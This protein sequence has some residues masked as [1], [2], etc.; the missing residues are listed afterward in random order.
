LSI[1][2]DFDRAAVGH[3]QS[4]VASLG[5]DPLRR[6]VFDLRGVTFMDRAALTTILRVDERG[7]RE[8]F[9][10]VVVRPPSLGGRVFT[11]SKAR[12]HLTIVAH[13]SE[14]MEG[15]AGGP[16]ELRRLEGDELTTCVRCRSN[17]A[18]WEGG[19]AVE[20]RVMLVSPDGP[21]CGGCITREEEIELGEAILRDLRRER[22]Q[23]EPRIGVLVKALSELRGADPDDRERGG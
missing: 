3:V 14:A 8:G 1:G 12:E 23:D 9:D 11:L 7:R 2:G 16:V 22:P 17:P 21:I 18:A 19:Q 10:V 4:A 5:E 20:G 15:G 6:V 13:P